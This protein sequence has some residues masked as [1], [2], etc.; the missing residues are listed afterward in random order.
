M[1]PTA[2]RRS[3][4]LARPPAG[5]SAALAAL[6]WA[7]K[8]NWTKAHRVAMDAEGADCAWVHAYLHRVEGDEDNARYW[9]RQA[10]R[11]LPTCSLMDEWEAIAQAVLSRNAS[12]PTQ[13]RHK[14]ALPRRRTG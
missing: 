3:I 14:S 8:G 11:K 1:T 7:K 9:Y 6:W 13:S 2:F 12:R 4:A 5:L 10:R